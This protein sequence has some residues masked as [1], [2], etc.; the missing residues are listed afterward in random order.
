MTRRPC[1]I[2]RALSW[3][4]PGFYAYCARCRAYHVRCKPYPK[5]DR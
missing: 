2:A 3:T 5:A 1:R 4:L